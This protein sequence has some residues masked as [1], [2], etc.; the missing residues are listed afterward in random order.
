MGSGLFG[1]GVSGLQSFQTALNTTGHNIANVNTDGYSRQETLFEQR[2]PQNLG[3]G[4]IGTGVEVTDIRRRYDQFVVGQV[5]NSTSAYE[6][7]S[8]FYNLASQVDNLLA[9]PQVGLSTGLENFFNAVQEVS[10]DP[11]SIAARQVMLT[12]SE[13]LIDRFSYLY[14]RLDNLRLDSNNQIDSYVAEINSLAQSIADIN[15]DIVIATGRSSGA[16]PNDLLDQRDALVGKLSELVSVRT[17]EQDDGSMSVFIGNGQPLVIG[18]VASQLSSQAQGID[19]FNLDISIVNSG[20]AVPIT[21]FITGGK[22]G[23]VLEFRDGMLNE[24][25]NSLGRIAAGLARDFNEQHRAGYDLDGDINQAY[26]SEPVPEVLPATA[27]TGT[28]AVS[29]SDTNQLTLDDYHMTYNGAAWEVRR[30]SDQQLV[31]F[32]GTGT[33]V[34]PIVFNGV[35]VEVTSAAAAGDEYLIRP[36]RVA[37]RDVGTLLTDPRDVAATAGILAAPDPANTGS[38][39]VTLPRVIDSLNLDLANPVTITYNAGVPELVVTD[40][41]NPAVN[42]PY[43]PATDSPVTVQYNGWELELSGVP[44]N[45]DVFNVVQNPDTTAIGDNRNALALAALQNAQTLVGGTATYSESYNQLVGSVGVQTRKAEITS[46]AQ[47]KLLSD[48]IS[49]REAI[50]G[51]N[52]DEEAANLLR[53]QQAYQASAQVIA[54]ANSLFDTLLNAVR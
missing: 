28:L 17:L 4:F 49:T 11:T 7:T 40:G 37:A 3:V 5:Q 31:S 23:G 24:A 44:A 25:Q 18:K 33:A 46:V 26:F 53:Y 39:E 47:E 20:A 19:P 36:T 1:I 16:T 45:V 27:N 42:I 8:T 2:L 38:A 32:T 41:V 10:N 13:S 22:L 6:Q 48:A 21:E 29:I 35:S 12:E 52:L 51:V 43:D 14:D 34:D 54:T 50:S 9:D 15:D 30:V